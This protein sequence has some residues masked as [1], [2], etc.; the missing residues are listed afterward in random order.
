VAQGEGGLRLHAHSVGGPAPPVPGHSLQRAQATLPPFLPPPLSTP[1]GAQRGQG[2]GVRP[3]GP[4]LPRQVQGPQE[5]LVPEVSARARRAGRSRGPR[6]DRT[7]TEQPC[8]WR[9]SFI[10][11]CGQPAAASPTHRLAHPARP[12]PP[13]RE[14]RD[15]VTFGEGL[16]DSVYLNAPEHVELDVGTGGCFGR[17]DRMIKM[18]AG[19]RA[20]RGGFGLGA[21]RGARLQRGRAPA[22]HCCPAQRALRPLPAPGA[23]VAIDASGWSDVVV[24]NPHLTMKVRGRRGPGVCEQRALSEPCP[25]GVGTAAVP[26]LACARSSL[27]PPLP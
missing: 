11:C 20:A 2:E 23:A 26:L 16:V 6:V 25:Q 13:K 7:L 8:D 12:P 1:K 3:Q 27:P 19:L 9:A 21:R 14:T 18:G 5:P 15:Q 4:H 24:W 17:C 10:T 22:R